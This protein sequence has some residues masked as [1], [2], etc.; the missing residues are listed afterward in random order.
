MRKLPILSLLLTL[1]L[2][3]CPPAAEFE[4]A[5]QIVTDPAQDAFGTAATIE[6]TVRYPEGEPVVGSIDPMTG[7]HRLEGLREGTGVIIDVIARDAAGDPVALGRSQPFD[8]GASGADAAVFVGAADSLARVEGGLAHARTWAAAQYVP[9]GRVV[10]V[11]G[12][13]NADEPVGDV[14]FIGWDARTPVHGTD[15][16]DFPRLGHALAY[17]PASTDGPWAGRVLSIGGTPDGGVDTLD[18]TWNQADGVIAAIDPHTGEVDDGAG[19]LD[20]GATS[21]LHHAV[22]TDDGWIAL[23]GGFTSGGSYHEQIRLIDPTDLSMTTTALEISIREQHRIT[24]LAVSGDRKVLI[25]GGTTNGTGPKRSLELWDLEANAEVNLLEDLQ[26]SEP[27]LRHTATALGSGR[28]VLA[29]GSTDASNEYARGTSTASADLFDPVFETVTPLPDMQVARQR[30][31]AAAIGDDRV[32]VCGGENSNGDP[33]ASCEVFTDT[34]TG[35][36]WAPFTGG[37]MAPGGPGV[38]A[39]PFPDGRVLFLG[40]WSALGPDDSVYLYTPTTLGPP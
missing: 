33:L 5:L 40:G 19:A 2:L 37:A 17:V 16:A 7:E 18:G 38:A 8:V 10:V 35:G 27:R 13:D 32:L 22:W 21:A 1:P 6:I 11:G 20:N 25:S 34:D 29:G 26:M 23:L 28:V 14:E 39:V 36:T 3:A 12:G 15:G 31:T 30:H 4:T 24:E 9:G